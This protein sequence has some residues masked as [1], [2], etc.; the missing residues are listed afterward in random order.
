MMID[1][2]LLT[3]GLLNSETNEGSI[4]GNYVTDGRLTRHSARIAAAEKPTNYLVVTDDI[5]TVDNGLAMETFP[6]F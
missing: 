6:G 2:A 5:L 4:P 3:S 1:P